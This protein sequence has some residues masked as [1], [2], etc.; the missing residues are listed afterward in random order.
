MNVT[1]VTLRVTGRRSPTCE[2]IA[3]VI[4][5]R[6]LQIDPAVQITP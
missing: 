5:S 2:E 3:G 4:L 6:S 1:Y